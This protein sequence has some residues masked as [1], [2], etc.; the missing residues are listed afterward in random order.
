MTVSM[1]ECE[2]NF[3][4]L[5]NT[6]IKSLEREEQSVFQFLFPFLQNPKNG[7]QFFADFLSKNFHQG[8]QPGCLI[9]PLKKSMALIKM[10]Q[11]QWSK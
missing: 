4:S 3:L 8:G 9:P 10:N 5:Q 11:I 1:I 7:I 6:E 2:L